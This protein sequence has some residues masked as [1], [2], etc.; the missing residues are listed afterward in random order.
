MASIPQELQ[1]VAMPEGDIDRALA[2]AKPANQKVR[3]AADTRLQFDDEPARF[4][5]FLHGQ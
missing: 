1:D 3:E 4:T 2:T 5:A